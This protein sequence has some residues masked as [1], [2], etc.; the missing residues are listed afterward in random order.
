MILV[1]H[2]LNM[3]VITENIFVITVCANVMS[4][5]N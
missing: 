3:D 1:A 4:R 2:F 5:A